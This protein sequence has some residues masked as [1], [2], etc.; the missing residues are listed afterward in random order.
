[1]EYKIKLQ[2]LYVIAA[3]SKIN[4]NMTKYLSC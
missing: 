1:L 2:L 3:Y 4:I